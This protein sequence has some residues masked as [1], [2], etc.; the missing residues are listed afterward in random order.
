MGFFLMGALPT[1]CPSPLTRDVGLSPL[2]LMGE[3]T[4]ETRNEGVEK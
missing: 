4:K 2:L 1:R 3:N